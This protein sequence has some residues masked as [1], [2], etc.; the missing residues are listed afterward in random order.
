MPSQQ[1]ERILWLVA[2]VELARD[3]SLGTPLRVT[4]TVPRGI[5]LDIYECTASDDIPNSVI[6]NLDSNPFSASATLVDLLLAN[7]ARQRSEPP[8]PDG[9][10]DP[11]SWRFNGVCF[12]EKLSAK[13]WRLADYLY[14][15]QPRLVDFSELGEPV[16]Q[17]SAVD[18]DYGQISTYRTEVNRFFEKYGIPWIVRT[19]DKIWVYMEPFDRP[20][21]EKISEQ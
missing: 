20:V 9:P 1:F 6:A 14:Q 13:A 8:E 18:P 12:E 16:F 19:S 11:F 3:S 7:V 5:G 2:I 10:C 21:A 15:R 17:D 4:R